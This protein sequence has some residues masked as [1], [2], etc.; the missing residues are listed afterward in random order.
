MAERKRVLPLMVA[1]TIKALADAAKP[2]LVAIKTQEE[3]VA[4]EQKKLDDM[5]NDVVEIDRQ[6]RNK[7]KDYGDYGLDDIFVLETKEVTDSNGR[8]S[9]Q[10]KMAWRHKLTQLPPKQEETNEQTETETET[11]TTEAEIAD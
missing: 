8:V 3:K 10:N 4:A 2:A 6:I 5:K 7:L 9:K 11:E 1:S